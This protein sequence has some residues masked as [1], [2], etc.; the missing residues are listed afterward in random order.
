MPEG[1]SSAGQCGIEEGEMRKMVLV[2]CATAG[3][4][5][6]GCG[7]TMGDRA[8]S[9]AAIGAGSGAAAGAMFGGLGVGT[10]AAIGAVVGGATGAITTE[11]QVDLGKPVWR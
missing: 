7:D 4:G 10:G 8:L 9:G 2:L 1:S 5:L 3:L 11:D 6:T